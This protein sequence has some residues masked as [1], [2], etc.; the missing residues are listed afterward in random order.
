MSISLKLIWLLYHQQGWASTSTNFTWKWSLISFCL[1][2]LKPPAKNS[3]NNNKRTM[4]CF[5]E[6]GK[7]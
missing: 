3:R 4:N 7:S 2:G 1:S 6:T 5:P